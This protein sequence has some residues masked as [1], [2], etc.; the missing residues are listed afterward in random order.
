[1]ENIPPIFLWIIYAL[2]AIVFVVWIRGLIAWNKTKPNT[3]VVKCPRCHT[4]S[5]WLTDRGDCQD[6]P[7]DQ[8]TKS[9]AQA[10]GGIV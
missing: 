7:G 3:L 5:G 2:T 6:C 9:E 8:S 10:S 4:L 1:M